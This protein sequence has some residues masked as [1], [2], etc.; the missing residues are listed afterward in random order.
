MFHWERS[1]CVSRLGVF[2]EWTVPFYDLCLLVFTMTCVVTWA[3]N[4]GTTAYAVQTEYRWPLVWRIGLAAFAGVG[5]AAKSFGSF[6][7]SDLL[8]S[9]GVGVR[10]QASE[11][12]RCN[13]S[14]DF[15]VSKET[16]VF[17]FYRRSILGEVIA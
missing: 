12:A 15:A 16:K 7:S 6:T 11:E 3:G 10:F 14:I 2:R 17:Y 9:A 8:P 13:V 4:T 1:S 5:S